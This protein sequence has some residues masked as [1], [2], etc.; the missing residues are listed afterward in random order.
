MKVQQFAGFF[1]ARLRLGVLRKRNDLFWLPGWAF[2]STKSQNLVG[3]FVILS[4]NNKSYKVNVSN[5][6]LRKNAF[7]VSSHKK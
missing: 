5:F 6:D 4:P 2:C 7:F 1:F 3:K